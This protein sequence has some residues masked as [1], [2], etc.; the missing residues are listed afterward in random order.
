MK[1]ALMYYQNGKLLTDC[2]CSFDQLKE[3]KQEFERRSI[4]SRV[5]YIF[6]PEGMEIF[7]KE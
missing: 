4:R 7:V 1:Y 6:Y 2:N 3:A 5:I